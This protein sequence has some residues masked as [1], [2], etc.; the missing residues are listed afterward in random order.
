MATVSRAAVTRV[1]MGFSRIS[2]M[3]EENTGISY[4]GNTD[5]MRG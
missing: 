1:R 4:R 2:V 3:A 5:S